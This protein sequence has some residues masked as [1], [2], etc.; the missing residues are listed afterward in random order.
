MA[1]KQIKGVNGQITIEGDWLTIERKGFFGRIGHSKGDK[2]IPLAS[3]TAVQ[4]RPAGSLANGFIRF[5]IPGSPEL[6]GG[7]GNAQKDENAV[8]FKKNQAKEFEQLRTDV[9]QYIASHHQGSTRATEPD[10][11]AQIE[12]LGQLRDQ[13]L[14]TADEFEAKKADLLDRM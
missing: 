8:I 14:I 9:E 10:I 12:K 7:L 2:R 11:P 6:R 5:T 13:G 1:E 3:I 4:M